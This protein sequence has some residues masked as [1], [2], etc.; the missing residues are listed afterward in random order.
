MSGSQA[1]AIR[2]MK[3]RI[4]ALTEENK[5]VIEENES[6]TRKYEAALEKLRQE[7]IPWNP[8]EILMGRNVPRPSHDAMMLERID[9]IISN[10]TQL[11]ANT[12]CPK[13][14]FDLIY[15]K[16]AEHIEDHPYEAMLYRDNVERA[17]EPGNRCCLSIK[18]ALFM[19][20]YYKR[21]HTSQWS[22]AGF[23]GIDQS[24]VSRGMAAM[25]K[26]LVVVL[27]TANV[28]SANIGDA[29]TRKKIKSAIPG[30]NGGVIMVDGTHIPVKRPQNSRL[31]TE[32]Y[33]GKKKAFTFN[34]TIVSNQKG[35]IIAIGNTYPGSTHDIEMIK[36][37]RLPLGYMADD[38]TRPDIPKKARINVYTDAGY[39][40]IMNPLP[41]IN[42]KQPYKRP[43]K[44]KGKPKVKLTPEQKEH[45]KRINKIRITIEHC[46][47]RMKKYNILKGQFGGTK[48]EL[49][50][51]INI[52]TGLVN[53]HLMYPQIKRGTEPWYLK[54]IKN[55][56]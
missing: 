7:N 12:G 32:V 5:A 46:I 48:E 21:N 10:D 42:S 40:G 4:S 26:I 18:H 15:T 28:V 8:E 35:L 14:E 29:W 56:T 36:D 44:R 11:L 3:R 20:L 53:L 41:G 52:I 33:S 50:E 37:R 6:I 23:F 47:G 49:N 45:N 1:K 51:E 39:V 27:P 17:E 16:V 25:N 19:T 2:R 31:R 24:N 30:P 9:D 22:V 55:G 34:T 54:P 13:K 43:R 38:M